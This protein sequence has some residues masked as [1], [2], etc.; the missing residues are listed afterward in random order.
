MSIKTTMAGLSVGLAVAFAAPNASAQED[1]VRLGSVLAVT[2]P[3]AFLGAPEQKTLEYY[4]GQINEDG[5]ID[6][7]KIDLTIYDS[8]G[9]ANKARTFA[10]RLVEEDEVD[11]VIGGTT[12]GATM[13]MIP[14]FEN[15]EVPLISL[16]GGISIVDPVKPYIF[17]MPHTDLMACEKIF[18]DM[19]K[20][21]YT[22]VAM[23][24]GTG[25]FGASMREQCLEVADD[26]GVKIVVDETYNPQD[27]DMTAQIT[28]ISNTEGV[29][30]V[31]NAGF[32]QGPAVFTRNYAQLG[33]KLPLYQSHGVASKQFIKLA[34][35]SA[36]GVRLPAAALLV[37]DQLPDG[38]PQKKVVV[39]Y[40]DTYE[41]VTGEQVST[42]GGH[43]YDAL[44]ILK[45]AVE[46]AGSTEPKAIRDAIEQTEG[47]V[48]TGGVF[49][50]SAE[51][52]LGLDESAFRMLEIKD[53]DWVLAE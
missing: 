10:Q 30:A 39:D 47:V 25:G 21:G 52:H 2:G 40:R 45:D 18:S 22:E 23:I 37:A 20:R 29:D 38:D 6:G 50:M 46:R 13:A 44:M 5:G 42:F 1:T 17:K 28:E 41:K 15:H 14:V 48:G 7:K 35:D 8:G 53:G 43:A 49:N 26:K 9:D 11:V 32:G 31:L 51:D 27:T 12:T 4:V 34:G 16:A 19:K 3:A 33:M 36:E 24:S